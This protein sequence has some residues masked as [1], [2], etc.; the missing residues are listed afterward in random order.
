MRTRWLYIPVAILLILAGCMTQETIPPVLEH[1]PSFTFSVNPH[2]QQ[3]RLL[4]N[5]I[6][7]RP[8]LS[9]L[10]TSLGTRK[11]VPNAELELTSYRHEFFPG[12]RMVIYAKFRNVTSEYFFRQPFT[13]SGNENT[14]NIVSSTEPE[15]TDDHLG[16]NGYLSPNEVTP[17]DWLGDYSSWNESYGIELEFE[18]VHKGEPFIYLVDAYA[19]VTLADGE[20]A[21]SGPSVTQADGKKIVGGSTRLDNDYPENQATGYAL[22]RYQPDGQLDT[23][24]GEAGL[25]VAAYDTPPNL[26]PDHQAAV[27]GL[28]LQPDGKIVA[29]G[30]LEP[31]GF[32]RD[33][34]I[35]RFNE[36]G[37]LDTDFGDNGIYYYHFGDWNYF[38]SLSVSPAGEIVVTGI[39]TGC[40]NYELHLNPDGSYN[41]YSCN[42]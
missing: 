4:E 22:V 24:F 14:S 31:S 26:N 32:R 17:P 30:H 41:T 37:S 27:E 16:G 34:G 13:F 40:G 1:G 35:V 20:K 6:D 2:T 12:N 33:Q 29:A 28:V 42:R 23:D 8:A 3:V 7:N 39:S 10:T 18:V 11:L 21:W 19:T 5:P 25:A 38:D 15:L 9:P 36:D